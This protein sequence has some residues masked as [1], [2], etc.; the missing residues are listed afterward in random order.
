M[1][2]QRLRLSFKGNRTYVQGPDIY[3]AINGYLTESAIATEVAQP[4]IRFHR[5]VT[6][7]LMAAPLDRSAEPPSVSY[8]FTAAGERQHWALREVDVEPGRAE[9]RVPYPEEDIVAA[10]AFD[11]AGKT[12]VIETVTPYSDLEV[13]TALNKALHQRVLAEATAQGKW[14]LVR[15]EAA[16]Y[17][18]RTAYKS[19]TVQLSNMLGVSLTKSRVDIDG[20]PFGWIYFRLLRPQVAS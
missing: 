8:A 6:K 5:L 12:A 13:Y 3:A 4:D 2:S 1:T 20:A 7:D 15:F 9:V 18:H 17:V 10:T 19:V 16:R 11:A 14:L